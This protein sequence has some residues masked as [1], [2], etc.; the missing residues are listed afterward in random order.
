MGQDQPADGPY[1]AALLQ[2]PWSRWWYWRP[3]PYHS[4][5]FTLLICCCNPRSVTLCVLWQTKRNAR[6]CWTSWSLV[7]CVARLIDPCGQTIISSRHVH[8]IRILLQC[9]QIMLREWRTT[10]LLLLQPVE[11]KYCAYGGTFVELIALEYVFKS[12]VEIG[13]E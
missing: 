6:C 7:S 3:K 1:S 13:S 4:Q 5:I 11:I 12:L 8:R 2:P 9:L 10:E